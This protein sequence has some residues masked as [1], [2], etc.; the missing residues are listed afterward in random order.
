LI[1]GLVLG[2]P[3]P[4]GVV[5]FV[6]SY[7]AARPIHLGIAGRNGDITINS[8]NK[9]EVNVKAI[10]PEQVEIQDQVAADAI[11]ITVGRPRMAK[12]DFEIMATGDTSV[13][14]KSRLSRVALSGITGHISVDTL[15]G[16]IT[17]TDV[18]SPCV[19]AKTLIGDIMFDGELSGE[20]PYNLQSVTGDIDVSL[21]AS[22]SFDLV[23]KSL[24]SSINLGGFFLSERSQDNDW[25]AGKHERGG[26][27]L[28][29]TTFEG[30]IV[31]HKK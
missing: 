15:N 11:A 8:W 10:S 18:H 24:S 5:R 1:F 19:E 23:A 20:G 29:L 16:D 7:N 9:R 26:P 14:V 30:R 28:N 25:V 31:L 17:L 12:V 4:L 22:M 21:P 6:R 27:R 3:G 2:L 13:S